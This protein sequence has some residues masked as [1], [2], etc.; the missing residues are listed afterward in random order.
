MNIL[1]LTN[2]LNIGGITRYVLNLS[3][4]LKSQGHRVFVGSSLGW[5]EGFLREN[6]ISFLRLPLKTKSIF[7]PRLIISYFILKRFI[8]KHNITIIHAQTRITQ[9]LGLLLSRSL[10]IAYIS[11]F[12]GFYRPHLI[13]KMIPCLGNLTIAISRAVGQHLIDDF[14]LDPGNLSVIYNS[15]NPEFTPRGKGDSRDYACFKGSPTLGIIARLSAEK[16]HVL[17]FSAFKQLIKDYPKARLLVVGRGKKENELKSW[18][19][20]EGLKQQVIFLG[21]VFNLSLLFSVLDLSILPSTLEG[22]G[23]SILEAQVNGVPVVANR[24]GG[25]TEIITDRETGILV[26]ASNPNELYKGIR[27]LLEDPQLRGRIINNAKQQIK[28]KFTLEAMTKGV[29]FVYKESAAK[30]STR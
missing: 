17:L 24:I 12:H 6:G 8:K 14:N 7:S 5:G 16:G 30:L 11:T 9:F 29:E 22:L 2:H 26:D 3:Y 23:F 4:G 20:K 25:I 15:V 18:I 27:L 10:K 28:E 1:I 21:N 19:E 13:R